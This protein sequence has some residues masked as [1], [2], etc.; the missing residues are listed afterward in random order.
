MRTVKAKAQLGLVHSSC[1]SKLPLRSQ[2]LSFYHMTL[3]GLLF[4]PFETVFQSI[5]GR[6]PEREKEKR[7]YSGENK[8]P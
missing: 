2:I 7:K 1:T 6:P 8:C 3:V 4:W 5:S